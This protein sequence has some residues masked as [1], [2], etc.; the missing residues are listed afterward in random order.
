MPP[1]GRTPTNTP[2]TIAALH[3]DGLTGQAQADF[4]KN[5]QLKPGT[6][7][8]ASY[9][10]TFLRANSSLLLLHP[11]TAIYESKADPAT[12]TVDLTF[13]AQ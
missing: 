6:L 5:W 13:P 4:E 10:R 12:H 3:A 2:Y 9:P 11:Y 8:K 7:Y 1:P